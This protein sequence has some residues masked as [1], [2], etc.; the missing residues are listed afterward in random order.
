MV[1]RDV[2]GKGMHAVVHDQ[3]TKKKKKQIQINQIHEGIGHLHKAVGQVEGKKT[4]GKNSSEYEKPQP[5]LQ[6]D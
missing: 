1:V 3:E 5:W 6:L 2:W 4:D